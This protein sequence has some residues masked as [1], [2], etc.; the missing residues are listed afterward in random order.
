MGEAMTSGA[1]KAAPRLA[2]GI[3]VASGKGGVGKTWLSATLCQVLARQGKKVL[4]F[5]G[6]LGLANVDIQ[7]GLA[8]ERDL[9]GV[10]AGRYPLRDAVSRCKEG[11][12][13]VIAGRSGSGSLASVAPEPLM[14]L[15]V[16]L[17]EL[18]THYDWV[19]LDLGAGI[20]RT[21]RHLAAMARTCLVVATDE[22]TAM[23]DAYALIKLTRMHDPKA[24]MRLVINMAQDRADG[25]RTYGT[26]R[27]A[28]ESF[29]KVVPPLAG[30]IARDPKVREA[31][32]HQV[33][34]LVRHPSA[35]AVE[36]VEA[37]ARRATTSS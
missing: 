20:E 2:N 1:V 10:L 17:I 5:D 14:K 36:D 23:T 28:C 21:V 31:I 9:G 29:L 4:L 13:D 22:P 12:F 18:S 16:A 25:E 11:N 8:P 3:A 7:L 37:V 26:L 33:P 30:V 27:K 32:R 35:S 19:V 15:C 24:D 6:D 34:L